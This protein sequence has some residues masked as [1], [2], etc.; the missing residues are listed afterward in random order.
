MVLE[1]GGLTEFAA[2]NRTTLYRRTGDGTKTY[3]VNLDE[4]LSQGNLET[5]TVLKPGDVVAVPER[6]F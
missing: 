4:I 3:S 6:F 2:P 5:N 1:A